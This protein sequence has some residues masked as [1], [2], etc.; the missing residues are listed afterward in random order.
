[1]TNDYIRL[2]FV[3]YCSSRLSSSW[4]EKI[5]SYVAWIWWQ[6]WRFQWSRYPGCPEQLCFALSHSET[7][8]KVPGFLKSLDGAHVA[9]GTV[10]TTDMENVGIFQQYSIDL[11]ICS[12]KK[13]TRIL[14]YNV[15]WVP[16]VVFYTFLHRMLYAFLAYRYTLSIVYPK[17]LRPE[18]FK[19]QGIFIFK[20][21]HL[22]NALS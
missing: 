5:H 10:L 13:R 22:N 3:S 6:W 21:L 12:S 11:L 17:C 15:I 8:L 7:S 1:M 18:Y 19:F 20:Y 9:W 16:E 2:L 14:M 4:K